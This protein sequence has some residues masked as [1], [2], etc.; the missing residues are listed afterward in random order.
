MTAPVW[1][2]VESLSTRRTQ[3]CESALVRG[4]HRAG[5]RYRRLVVGTSVRS[6]GIRRRASRL[7][8][9]DRGRRS[10]TGWTRRAAPPRWASRCVGMAS[11]PTAIGVRNR[12]CVT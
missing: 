11:P 9:R 1:V 4:R 7:A 3:E 10:P 5:V 2:V 12:P 6:R 8:N